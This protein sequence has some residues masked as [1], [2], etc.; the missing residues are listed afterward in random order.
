[1]KT[2]LK[3]PIYVEIESDNIDRKII[4]DTSNSVLYPALIQYLSN[5]KFRKEILVQFKEVSKVANLDIK[6]LTEIDLFRNRTQD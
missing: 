6:L 2:V 4:T 1:M 3:Y 5:A